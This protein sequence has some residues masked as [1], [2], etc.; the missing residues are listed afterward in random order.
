VKLCVP[1]DP[2]VGDPEITPLE[3]RLRPGGND[4]PARLNVASDW[5]RTCTV[6]L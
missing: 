6:W 4:P 1:T 2:I 3:A 5:Q